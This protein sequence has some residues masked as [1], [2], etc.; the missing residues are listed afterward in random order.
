MAPWDR[1]RVWRGLVWSLF[2]FYATF[3]LI[4]PGALKFLQDPPLVQVS[5]VGWTVDYN[6]TTDDPSATVSLLYSRNFG[7]SYSVLQASPNKL[8]LR[9]QVFTLVNLILS[10]GGYYKCK[11]TD[12]S[13]QTIQWNRVSVLFLQAGL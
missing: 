3:L 4:T 2:A 6:C 5:L 13:G 8:L 1:C 10:D 11:A 7:I 9:K 12:Q